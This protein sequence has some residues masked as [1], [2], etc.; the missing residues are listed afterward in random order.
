MTC[1]AD[2]FMDLNRPFMI[3]FDWGGNVEYDNGIIKGD[4]STLTA[5]DIIRRKIRY[6]QF[7]DLVYALVGVEKSSYKLNMSLCYQY[8]GRSNIAPLINDSTLD[9][10]YYLAETNESY[11][12][13]VCVEFEEMLPP[14]NTSFVDL[15]RNFEVPFPL[16]SDNRFEPNNE[17]GFS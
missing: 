7:K 6:E 4:E 16:P 1:Y 13:Q 12:G 8:S 10:M 14:T 15:M 9:M 5:S 11:C 2:T 3:T 17:F